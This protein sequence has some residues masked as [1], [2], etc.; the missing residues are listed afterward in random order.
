[1]FP[2]FLWHHFWRPLLRRFSLRKRRSTAQFVC[3]GA[4]QFCCTASKKPGTLV[5]KLSKWKRRLPVILIFNPKIRGQWSDTPEAALCNIE[6]GKISSQYE[7]QNA[8]SSL[9]R[10]GDILSLDHVYF[11]PNSGNS[12]TS[13]SSKKRRNLPIMAL[14]RLALFLSAAW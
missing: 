11:L 8:R 7:Q 2:T 9:T 1:M 3:I 12:L 5:Q 6:P 10:V 4:S 14:S 13:E